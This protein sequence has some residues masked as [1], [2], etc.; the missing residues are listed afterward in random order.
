MLHASCGGV[1]ECQWCQLRLSYASPR[2]PSDMGK[3]ALEGGKMKFTSCFVTAL[4]P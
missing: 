4:L 1:S 2:K 3:I